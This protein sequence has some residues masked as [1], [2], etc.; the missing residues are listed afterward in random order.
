M[1]QDMNEEVFE[2][3]NRHGHPIHCVYDYREE[4]RPLI[5]IP[6]SW[7]GTVRRSL[8]QMLYLINAGFNVC[9]FDFTFHRGNSYGDIKDYT[10]TSAYDDVAAVLDFV[11]GPGGIDHSAGLGVYGVSMSSRVMIRYLA[12]NP[13]AADVFVSLIGV[14][15]VPY[16]VKAATGNDFESYYRDPHHVFGL[17]KGIHYV[18]DW[19]RFIRDAVA[20]GWHTLDGTKREV[21]LMTTP[22]FLIVAEADHWID[23]DDYQYVYGDNKE[24]LKA[25]YKLPNAGHE[26]YKN[27]EAAKA[28][29]RAATQ[30]FLRFFGGVEMPE[31]PEPTITEIID[32]N[33]RERQRENRYG[34]PKSPAIRWPRHA[35]PLVTHAGTAQP[36]PVA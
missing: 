10:L 32:Q 14:V 24:I 34:Q 35:A 11:R 36:R 20:N 8:V 25:T 31:L 3:E 16:T 29:T 6:P 23:L 18:V 13:G 21:D 27:P 5:V 33:T 2:I 12:A 4:G 17:N 7:E 28:A 19:D 15:D 1:I 22:T 30:E 9:R 26:L